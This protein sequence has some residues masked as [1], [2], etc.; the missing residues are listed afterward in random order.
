MTNHQFNGNIRRRN[1]C[2]ILDVSDARR[3]H[4]KNQM[5]G[6]FISLKNRQRKSDLVVE[7]ELRGNAGSI[8]THNLEKQILRCR[9]P[10]RAGHRDNI[11]P[12]T[13]TQVFKV[14][15]GK[16]TQSVGRILDNN[17]RNGRGNINEVFNDQCN[18]TIVNGLFDVVMPVGGLADSC[19]IR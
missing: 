14:S 18:R 17:L 19:D 16:A 13:L 2:Q 8:S 15:M 12:K 11:Q 10:S 3:T 6:C 7:R 4:F 1:I 9:L 5:A